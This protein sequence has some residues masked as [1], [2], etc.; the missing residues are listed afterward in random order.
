MSN[1]Q[2][3]VQ[4]VLFAG[5]G[6]DGRLMHPH[7]SLPYD[8]VAPN[9]LDSTSNETLHEYSRRLLNHLLKTGVIKPEKKLFFGGASFGGAVAQEMSTMIKTEGVILLGS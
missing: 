9:Y 5:L 4:L 7:H 6:A 2:S 1:S 3:N 8:V